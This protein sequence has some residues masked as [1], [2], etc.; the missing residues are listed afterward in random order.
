MSILF[1]FGFFVHGVLAASWAE[2]LDFQAFLELLLVLKGTVV[3]FL[4]NSTLEFDEIFLG[5][6]A[7]K[8]DSRSLLYWP[9]FVN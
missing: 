7:K 8:I 5:H 3:W 6:T 1:L 4:T 9:N 2:L